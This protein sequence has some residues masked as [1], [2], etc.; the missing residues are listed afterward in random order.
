MSPNANVT[1]TN[2]YFIFEKGVEKFDK[3]L[4]KF[5][6]LFWSISNYGIDKNRIEFRDGTKG[7]KL[8]RISDWTGNWTGKLRRCPARVPGDIYIFALMILNRD[9]K[10]YQ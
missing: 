10:C 1:K 3:K 8:Q 6:S 7:L 4:K 2:F 9:V 5:K